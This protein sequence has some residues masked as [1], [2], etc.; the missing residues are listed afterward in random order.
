MLDNAKYWHNGIKVARHDNLPHFPFRASERFP[1]YVP[2]VLPPDTRFP[3]YGDYRISPQS[4]SL[5]KVIAVIQVVLAGRQLYRTY[6]TSIRTRGISSPYVVVIPYLMSLVNLIANTLVGSYTQVIALLMKKDTPP[7]TNEVFIGRWRTGP[8][9]V[10]ACVHDIPRTPDAGS[11][12]QIVVGSTPHEV[13]SANQGEARQ[14]PVS[15]S[16]VDRT[17]RR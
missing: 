12:P 7:N 10:I 2:F 15:R 6:D 16:P 1:C 9:R 13:E 8:H 14:S 3:G 4:N 5:A 17:S 11:D